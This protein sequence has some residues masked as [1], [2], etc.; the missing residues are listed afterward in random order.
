[1]QVDSNMKLGE[2]TGLCKIDQEGK[3]R[4]VKSILSS[5]SIQTHRF[6]P[7]PDLNIF[8]SRIRYGNQTFF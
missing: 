6:I 1:M 2:W 8:P 5:P 3:A 7:E 4:K